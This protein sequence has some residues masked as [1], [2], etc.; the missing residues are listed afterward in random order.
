MRTNQGKTT[1][2]SYVREHYH[3]EVRKAVWKALTEEKGTLVRVWNQGR[4]RK[5]Q[6]TWTLNR[7]PHGNKTAREQFGREVWQRTLRIQGEAGDSGLE[8][9][10][11]VLHHSQTYVGRKEIRSSEGA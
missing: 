1:T 5:A 3:P 9:R 2:V 8:R 10:K 11:Q 6:R 4:K 7:S